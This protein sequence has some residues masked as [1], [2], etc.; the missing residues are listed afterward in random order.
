MLCVVVAGD[1]CQRI[2]SKTEV[3]TEVKAV[4]IPNELIAHPHV[5]DVLKHSPARARDLAEVYN[6]PLVKTTF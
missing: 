5:A 2:H 6:G 4:K 1:K 3:K